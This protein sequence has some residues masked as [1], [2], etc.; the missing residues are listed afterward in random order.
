MARTEAAV[1]VVEDAHWID[2]ASESML[3]DFVAV[4]PR[5]PS[6]MLITYRPEYM[7]ALTRA[8]GTQTI[9]LR[10]LTDE[11]VS[12]LSTELLGADPSLTGLT[13]LVADRAAGN[14]FFACSI[15]ATNDINI[16]SWPDPANWF[17]VGESRS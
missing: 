14:P 13:A 9:A 2:E 10:P 17:T 4:I 3:A 15:W 1:Y 16:P 11:Q 6:L 12:T 5:T 7:G 8:Q